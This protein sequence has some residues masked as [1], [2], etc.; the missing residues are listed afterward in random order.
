VGA[1]EL[2][3]DE[4]GVD[5]AVGCTYKYLNGG[6]GSPAFAYSRRDL[7]DT[8]RQP[9]QGWMG[10]AD[11][12]EMGPGWRPAGGP[13]HLVSGTPPI[14]AMVPLLGTLELLD[15]V[16]MPAV[17]AKSVALTE[18]AIDLVDAW[19]VEHKVQVVSP[20][21]NARRGGH[22]TLRRP[23][24]AELLHPLWERGVLPDYRRPDGIRIGLSPLSTSFTEVYDG[25]R[26]LRDL[27]AAEDQNR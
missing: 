14:L 11:A 3:L 15:E 25:L 7:L 6:P 22:L 20:R 4:W 24:F 5:L 27:L 10:R 2:A 8:L 9:I 26:I 17:R 13:R 23:G 16:G 12:F 18:Y 19:L 21:D 1:V